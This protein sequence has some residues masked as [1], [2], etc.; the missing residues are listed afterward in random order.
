[1]WESQNEENIPSDEECISCDAARAVSLFVASCRRFDCPALVAAYFDP[2]SAGAC[3]A[4]SR[5]AGP[6]GRADSESQAEY[7]GCWFERLELAL[8]RLRH[9]C[10][11]DGSFKG[12]QHEDDYYDSRAPRRALGAAVWKMDGHSAIRDR[13]TGDRSRAV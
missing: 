11:G 13:V 9:P 7:I 1:M 10:W 8:H 2:E 3:R 5:D 6:I 4:E 12:N